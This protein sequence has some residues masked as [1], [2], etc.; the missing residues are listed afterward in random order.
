MDVLQAG[1]ELKAAAVAQ[2]VKKT[3]DM[4]APVSQD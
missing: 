2:L 4:E 3:V 1:L